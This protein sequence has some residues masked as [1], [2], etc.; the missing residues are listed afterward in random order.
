MS[1]PL[2][3]ARSWSD[4]AILGPYAIAITTLTTVSQ[5]VL[6][7]RGG[8]HTIDDITLSGSASQGAGGIK[9]WSSDDA[10]Y[11]GGTI[12]T[13]IVGI[14]IGNGWQTPFMY[15]R[16]A[17]GTLGTNIYGFL[18]ASVNGIVI[19]NDSQGNQFSNVQIMLIR[20]PHTNAETY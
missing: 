8:Q 3:S 4:Y 1:N 10:A 19:E 5:Q 13:N 17:V 11:I 7:D 20:L 15:L 2:P 14:N 6:L 18:A 16:R 12:L 9:I